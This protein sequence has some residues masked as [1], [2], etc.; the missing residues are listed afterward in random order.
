MQIPASS[1]IRMYVP[2]WGPLG[3]DKTAY[4]CKIALVLDDDGA[5]PADGDYHP[6]EWRDDE[7]SMVPPSGTWGGDYP[8]GVYMAWVRVDPPAETPV[9]MPAG[10]VRIGEPLNGRWG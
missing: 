9:I 8:D 5:E 2:V 4:P 7:A 1:G 6:G 3:I 10:R